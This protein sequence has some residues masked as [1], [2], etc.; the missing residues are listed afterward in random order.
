MTIEVTSVTVD[1]RNFTPMFSGLLDL[2]DK[3]QRKYLSI[4]KEYIQ[5]CID[6]A[7]L[8]CPEDMLD[9]ITT[10]DGLIV[11]FK[12]PKNH[13]IQSYIYS[14][15][16]NKALFGYFANLKLTHLKDS[17]ISGLGFGI[18]I[19]SGKC[20]LLLLDN[21][22]KNY[23]SDAINVSSRLEGM[24]KIFNTSVIISNSSFWPII[25]LLYSQK[26]KNYDDIKTYPDLIKESRRIEGGKEKDKIKDLWDLMTTI[27]E[28]LF[29][30]YLST[31]NLKGL[32]SPQIVYRYSKTLY[33]TNI[34]NFLDTHHQVL[35]KVFDKS[36]P[37]I[38]KYLLS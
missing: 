7:K 28:N 16:L 14:I 30:R 5:I 13:H 32:Q 25:D 33:S 18:G 36:Y 20:N 3:D 6:K 24:T 35:G 4:V 38:S 22:L 21:G 10:G 12:D 23:L 34:N 11:L 37:R 29:F 2:S 1:L 31:I 26:L 9:F 19:D 15:I 17:R 27:N 8:V